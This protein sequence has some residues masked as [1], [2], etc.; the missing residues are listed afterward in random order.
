VQAQPVEVN[1]MLARRVAALLPRF[2]Y[3]H[4][5]EVQLHDAIA[6]VLAEAGIPFQREV[7][8][9][10]RERF[11]FL[12]PPGIVLEVKVD[13]S[14]AAALGQC[15]RYAS[16]AD[17]TTVLLVSARPWRAPRGGGWQLRGK[18]VRLVNVRGAAF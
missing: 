6:A 15:D 16:R 14:L 10:P 4:A 8:A 5:N 1:P 9:G 11:D 13:G 17:V 12:V 3:R 18:S 2:S 7:V